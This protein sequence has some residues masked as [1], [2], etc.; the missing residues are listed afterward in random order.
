[1][2][3]TLT[4]CT[5]LKIVGEKLNRTIKWLRPQENFY[6]IDTNVCVILLWKEFIR[7]NAEIRMYKISIHSWRRTSKSITSKIY[8]IVHK[9]TGLEL[10]QNIYICDSILC[11]H[12]SVFCR[13][14]F[15]WISPNLMPIL[16]FRW[17]VFL[18]Y[19]FGKNWKKIWHIGKILPKNSFCSVLF[20]FVALLTPKWRP[21]NFYWQSFIGYRTASHK[22]NNK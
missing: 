20:F 10:P 5:A 1:M 14:L 11:R 21:V 2:V 17:P 22:K 6:K 18:S 3:S 9:H 15:I 7:L 13:D 16:Y 19:F 8:T 12:R 4:D